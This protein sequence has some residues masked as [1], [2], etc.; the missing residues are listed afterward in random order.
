MTF[1]N[2]YI[3]FYYQIATPVLLFNKQSSNQLPKNKK[4]LFVYFDYEREFSGNNYHISDE[5]L[6]QLLLVLKE[7]DLKATWFTLGKVIEKYPESIKKI[8]YQE[9][10]LGSHNFNHFSPLFSSRKSLINDLI[11]FNRLIDKK[12]EVKGF[13]SPQGLWS[14]TLLNLL[15]KHH[16]LYDVGTAKNSKYYTVNYISKSKRNHFYR[17]ITLGDDWPLFLNS[18]DP[19]KALDYFKSL[20]NKMPY[21]AIAGI[22]FHPWILFSHKTIWKGFVDFISY[23][24][25][26]E[27]YSINPAIQYIPKI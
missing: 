9:H 16:F 7:A 12:Y 20:L 19:A 21:G 26:N 6:D 5:Q 11:N 27:T 22:G 13:H 2:F 3:K 24:K 17:L 14:F 23:L 4:H 15:K 18:N 10:E 8:L 25:D 1:R